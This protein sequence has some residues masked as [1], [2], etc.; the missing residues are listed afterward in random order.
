M[1]TFLFLMCS[2]AI[3]STPLYGDE[4]PDDD[5]DDGTSTYNYSTSGPEQSSPAAPTFYSTNIFELRHLKSTESPV[6]VS[7]SQSPSGPDTTTPKVITFKELLSA[8]MV[9]GGLIILSFFLLISTLLLACKVCSLNKR[10]RE[11]SSDTDLV[12]TTDYQGAKGKPEKDVEETVVLMSDLSQTKEEMSNGTTKE[13]DEKNKMEDGDK[14]KS[15]GA[16]ATPAAAAESSSPSKGPEETSESL[17]AEATA[18]SNPE[19]PE[20][21]K[22]VV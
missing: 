14:I 3:L 13:E 22:D 12:I 18:A 21:P 7:Q 17:P 15:D 8:H 2:I 9:A 20:E 16:A 19:G 5:D 10:I 4:T 1:N 6:P 11:L